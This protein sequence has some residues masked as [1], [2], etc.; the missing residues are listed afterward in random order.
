M[1]VCKPK[2]AMLLRKM[3]KNNTFAVLKKK[4]MV[5]E[6]V[7]WLSIAAIFHSYVVFPL[8][9]KQLAKNKTYQNVVYTPTA[10]LPVVSVLMAAYNEEEV[11]EEKINSIYN[12]NYP[13]QQ[14]EVLIGSDNSTDRTNEIIE[15]LTQRFPSLYFQVFTTRQ[16]KARIINQLKDKAKGEILLLTDANVMFDSHTIFELVK[17]FKNPDI[18]LVDSQMINT[19]DSITKAGISIQESSYISREVMLKHHESLI[20]G[21]MMGPFG[22]CFAMRKT[23]FRP[24]PPNYLVDD[25]F[26][27]MSVLSQKQKA[28]NNIQAQVFEDVSNNLKDE[29]RRKVRIATG[30]FQNLLTFSHLLRFNIFRH[31]H[32]KGVAFC[33]WSHKVL[34]WLGPFFLIAVFISNLLL[35][36]RPFYRLTFSLYCASLLLPFVDFLLRKLSIHSVLLRFL[37]HFYSMNL[38]LLIGFF[39]YIKGVKTNVWQPTKRNQTKTQ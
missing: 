18:G 27:N 16:G 20:W 4:A 25:F 15:M 37:T 33:F 29:F 30:N 36:Q 8:I 13:P 2:A 39:K 9:L 34:R 38:A 7:F 10:P 12:T 21:C 32:L 5:L 14:L 1:V 19:S 6:I 35:V 23:L 31:T 22:G 17:Y 28:I 24:V 26:L 11:I 3:K